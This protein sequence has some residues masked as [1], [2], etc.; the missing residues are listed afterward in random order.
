MHLRCT[1]ITLGDRRREEEFWHCF[2]ATQN[3]SL[4]VTRLRRHA[5]RVEVECVRDEQLSAGSLQPFLEGFP[6]WCPWHFSTEGEN[7]ASFSDQ[8]AEQVR[9]LQREST[10]DGPIGQ[11]DARSD[12]VIPVRAKKRKLQ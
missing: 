1:F 6:D 12:L 10:D 5:D 4:T 11:S 7:H 8:A 3:V 2:H 9:R